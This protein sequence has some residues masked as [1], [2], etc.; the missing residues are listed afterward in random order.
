MVFIVMYPLFST[1]ASARMYKLKF[2]CTMKLGH[3]I[4]AKTNR[5][6]KQFEDRCQVAIKQV[7][8]LCTRLYRLDHVKCL[9]AI[10]QTRENCIK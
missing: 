6:P 10:T 5:L 8:N 1:A 9:C 4:Q 3:M 2:Y 7:S